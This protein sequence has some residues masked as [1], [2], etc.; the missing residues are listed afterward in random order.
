MMNRSTSIAYIDLQNVLT[1]LLLAMLALLA[2]VVVTIS[3]G[4]VSSKAEFIIQMSWQDNSRDDVDLWMRD[5][6]GNLLSFNKKDSGLMTLDRDDRGVNDI[7]QGPDGFP[8][9]DP[10]RHEMASIRGIIPGTYTVNVVLYSQQDNPPDHVHVQI[11]KLN[12]YQVVEDKTV[13]LVKKDQEITIASFS[14][15]SKGAVVQVDDK[16]QLKIVQ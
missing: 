10:S 16:T 1:G 3:H 12:P 4:D 2:T 7:V 13:D 14:I 9:I 11:I 8:V 15:D 5:P 6:S